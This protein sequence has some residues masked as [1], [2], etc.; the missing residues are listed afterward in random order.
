MHTGISTQKYSKLAAVYCLQ[1]SLNAHTE[2]SNHSLLAYN[3]VTG[4]M[5]VE[6]Q[7]CIGPLSAARRLWAF[8]AKQSYA[9]TS[10]LPV[11]NT[12]S[13]GSH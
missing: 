10:H 1:F 13:T 9:I 4:E 5:T 2:S 3:F 11:Q 6:F 8:I 12:A 7:F